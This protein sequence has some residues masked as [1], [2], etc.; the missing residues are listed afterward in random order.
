MHFYL[1]DDFV[2][3]HRTEAVLHRIEARLTEIGIQGRMEKL[4]ILKNAGEMVHEAV[5]RGADT[6][7]AIGDDRTVSKMVSAVAEHRVPFGIIP[8]GPNQSIAQA[9][10]IPEGAEACES[11]SRR[12]IEEV[13]LGKVGERYFLTAL[14]MPSG[15]YDLECD[16]QYKVHVDHAESLAVQNLGFGQSN[17][18]DGILEAV[19]GGSG[20]APNKGFSS[21]FRR[22]LDRPSVF[23]VKRVVITAP[24]P[25]SLL[26]DG[27]TLVKTPATVEATSKK[28]KIIVGKNRAF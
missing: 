20:Q 25:L 22:G 9:L 27:Q 18:K 10:G 15:I 2:S 21:F 19:V 4:T 28:L 16:G 8:V 6:I 24:Q 7:I 23:P 17:P 13:D 11:I 12:I 3:Q 1:V 5:R 14:T 26:L